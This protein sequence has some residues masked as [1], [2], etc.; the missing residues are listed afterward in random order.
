MV[1][2]ASVR[3]NAVNYAKRPNPQDLGKRPTTT[4]IINHPPLKYKR[5]FHTNS[6]E[7]TEEQDYQDQCYCDQGT[8][9]NDVNEMKKR[10]I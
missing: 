2:D 10:L 5:N 6:D 7:M 3:T 8:T 9:Y 1:V 4:S